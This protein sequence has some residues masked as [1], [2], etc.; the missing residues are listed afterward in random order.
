MGLLITH[1]KY[2]QVVLATSSNRILIT[3]RGEVGAAGFGRTLFAKSLCT[4]PEF[5]TI[6][7]FCG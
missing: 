5:R 6:I 4:T 3:L 7:Q 2:L 1:Y